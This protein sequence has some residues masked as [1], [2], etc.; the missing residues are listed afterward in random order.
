MSE[1]IDERYHQ[2]VAVLSQ[3]LT[4]FWQD[5]ML[6]PVEVARVVM[7]LWLWISEHP[8]CTDDECREMVNRIWA[9]E[10]PVEQ[11]P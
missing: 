1:E 7:R 11:V 8:D 3:R 5:D 9:I 6:C 10:K 2:L 4:K